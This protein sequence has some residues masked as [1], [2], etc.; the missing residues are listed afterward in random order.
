MPQQQIP[1]DALKINRGGR[2]NEERAS[3]KAKRAKERKKNRNLLANRNAKKQ[4]MI[5][6]DEGL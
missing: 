3:E 2:P 6:G 5:L 1:L 4:L